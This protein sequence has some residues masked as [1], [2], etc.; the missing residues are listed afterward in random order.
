MT[1]ETEM[2]FYVGA[3]ATS[4]ADLLPG[5]FTVFSARCPKEEAVKVMVEKILDDLSELDIEAAQGQIAFIGITTWEE[6][7][8]VKVDDHVKMAALSTA[9]MDLLLRSMASCSNAVL[10]LFN[11]FWVPKGD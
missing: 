3:Q 10:P 6:F 7:A 11:T 1:A 2:M 9:V 5:A 8:E 4:D